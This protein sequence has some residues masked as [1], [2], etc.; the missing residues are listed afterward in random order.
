MPTFTPTNASVSALAT[1]IITA[2]L[3][4]LNSI[5]AEE[6]I[7]AADAAWGLSKLQRLI[8]QFNARRAMIYNV[9][10]ALYTLTPNHAPHTIGPGGDFDVPLRPTRL[11]GANLVLT[12]GGT[13]TDLPLYIGDD[14][15]WDSIRIK[16]LT[17]SLCTGV[18]YSPDT[19]LG[20]LNFWP[21]PTAANQVRLETWVNLTQA[22]NLQTALA[23]PQGYWD[24]L[25]LSLAKQLAPSFGAAALAI[26]G[27]GVF[28]D[29][30]R[31]AM[32]ALQG[33]NLASPRINNNQAGMPGK[34]KIGSGKPDFNFL[35]GEPW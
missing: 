11:V 8:D 34:S 3:M 16:N 25:V 27:S 21:I 5:G 22:V 30:Y 1:D 18:Y 23:M 19:P 17:S 32:K 29:N 10:F 28:A 6:T 9:N 35:T 26:V 13:S 15:W 12:N 7:A 2:A 4:E 20:N 33:S 31:M 14:A 24:G